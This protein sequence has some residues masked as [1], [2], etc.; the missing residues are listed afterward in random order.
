MINNGPTSSSKKGPPFF[1]AKKSS[2]LEQG[3]VC[4][5]FPSVVA[6]SAICCAKP[7]DGLAKPAARHWRM[8]PAKSFM[9]SYTPFG[10]H[11]WIDCAKIEISL[12]WYRIQKPLQPGSTKKIRTKKIQNPPFPVWPPQKI[13]KNYKKWLFSCHF[14][15]LSEFFFF[16]RL[17]GAKPGPGDFVI[18]CIFFVF[19]GLRG[20]LYSVP[21][22]GDLNFTL[23]TY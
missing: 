1:S 21:P 20:F 17:F 12:G 16:F 14:W 22:Q 6:V 23:S 13:L 15:K 9:Q 2:T 5:L 4:F 10:K 11:Y 18:F 3:G 7:A 8:R 19:P